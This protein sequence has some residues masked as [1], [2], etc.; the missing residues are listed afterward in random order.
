MMIPLP[1]LSVTLHILLGE[2]CNP[3]CH[4]TYL[5]IQPL[6]PKGTDIPLLGPCYRYQPT[7]TCDLNR[8]NSWLFVEASS[9]SVS[10]PMT[11]LTAY[12]W[13]YDNEEAFLSGTLMRAVF[14][15]FSVP[16]EL[17]DEVVMCLGCSGLL[18]FLSYSVS[19]KVTNHSQG[20]PCMRSLYRPRASDG[21]AWQPQRRHIFLS[22]QQL[23]QFDF[24][25][26]YLHILCQ[27]QD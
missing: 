27:S 4:C 10:W 6:G 25:L 16:Q 2:L 23:S 20:D 7:T 17:L 9:S 12:S 14:L 24:L 15:Y 19:Q 13:D 18:N 22:L 21:T 8:H 3:S 26:V 1:P 11:L 5:H